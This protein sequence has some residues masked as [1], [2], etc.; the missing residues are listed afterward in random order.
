MPGTGAHLCEQAG[1]PRGHRR[2]QGPDPPASQLELLQRPPTRVQSGGPTAACSFLCLE[3]S[4]RPSFPICKIRSPPCTGSHGKEP[5]SPVQGPGEGP[6]GFPATRPP[7]SLA[8]RWPLRLLPSADGDPREGTG[9]SP[10]P[11]HRP[12]R[13]HATSHPAP[14][15]VRGPRGSHLDPQAARTP[16]KEPTV[17]P[18]RRHMAGRR[19]R[20]PWPPHA[21]NRARP[22]PAP[23]S[24]RDARSTN[25]PAP[26]TAR[27][28]PGG[29]PGLRWP[30]GW[31]HPVAQS[32]ARPRGRRP[33]LVLCAA[34]SPRPQARPARRMPEAL[35]ARQRVW[36]GN[37]TRVAASAER[38]LRAAPAGAWGT[39][40]ERQR[41][42]NSGRSCSGAGGHGRPGPTDGVQGPAPTGTL[43]VPMKP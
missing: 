29:Q 39:G 33:L 43:R 8:E 9:H 23:C 7:D 6:A 24:Q 26:R 21:E 25:E 13:D 15:R 38:Q 16:G 28:Q 14:R 37:V 40:T 5:A 19:A 35:G 12:R 10:W 30:R 42:P 18:R 22:P 36:H 11:Q 32:Q 31:G 4:A 34:S 41:D 1:V 2:S 17:H 3:T 20:G 27:G